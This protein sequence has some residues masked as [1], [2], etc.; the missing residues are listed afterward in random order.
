MNKDER[1]IYFTPFEIA[2]FVCGSA[3]FLKRISDFI[4]SNPPFGVDKESLEIDD[5]SMPDA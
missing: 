3:E 4:I 1:E 2:E 5:D